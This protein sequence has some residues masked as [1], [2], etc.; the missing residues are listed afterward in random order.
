MGAGR[1]SATGRTG[2]LSWEN[3]DPGGSVRGRESGRS[4]LASQAVSGVKCLGNLKG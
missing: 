2:G 3:S 4:V 1:A